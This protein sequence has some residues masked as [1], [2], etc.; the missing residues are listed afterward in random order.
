MYIYYINYSRARI[1]SLK[2]VHSQLANQNLA[3]PSHAEP[4]QHAP[5]TDARSRTRQAQPGVGP[6]TG[7]YGAQSW[8]AEIAGLSQQQQQP[9]RVRILAQHLLTLARAHASTH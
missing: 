2:L 5:Q 8:V 9:F 3:D 4:P 6:P 1:N 7:H